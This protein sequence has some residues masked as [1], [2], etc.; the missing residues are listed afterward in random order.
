MYCLGIFLEEIENF[1]FNFL[2]KI[3]VFN[4]LLTLKAIFF[5]TSFYFY[6]LVI[7]FKTV[8]RICQKVVFYSF[9]LRLFFKMYYF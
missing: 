8:I 6:S 5:S 4:L 3:K 9:T 2:S 1:N 7:I